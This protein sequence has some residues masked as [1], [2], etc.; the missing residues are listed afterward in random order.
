MTPS[1]ESAIAL[2]AMAHAGQKD[3]GGAPYILHVLWVM[4]SRMLQTEE[5]RMVAVMHDIA[6]DCPFLPL[7]TL[8]QMGYSSKVVD[9]LDALTR[10]RNEP[11]MAFIE[12]CKENPIARK[13][14]VVD[15]WH[16]MKADRLGRPPTP[17]DNA[18]IGRYAAAH[19]VLVGDDNG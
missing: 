9:A 2:A 5:E 14:K 15:L 18:R 10:R 11:Y 13:V 12:R 4:A 16:N 3:K 17:E 1:L 19:S 6:E 7:T 8:W